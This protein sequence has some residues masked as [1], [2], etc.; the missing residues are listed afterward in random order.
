MQTVQTSHSPSLGPQ[1]FPIEKLFWCP[2]DTAATLS[3]YFR[4]CLQLAV[5]SRYLPSQSHPNLTRIKSRT[6]QRDSDRYPL[7]QEAFR[8]RPPLRTRPPRSSCLSAM[9]TAHLT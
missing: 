5:T 4:D 2:F 6:G 3:V 8:L 9:K 1:L 7:L